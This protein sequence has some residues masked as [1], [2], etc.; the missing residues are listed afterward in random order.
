MSKTFIL[1]KIGIDLSRPELLEAFISRFGNPTMIIS[2]LIIGLACI[3]IFLL[4]Q[5]SCSYLARL[6]LTYISQ[7]KKFS[8]SSLLREWRG[9]WSWAGT[10]LVV[11]IYFIGASMITALI[12]IGCIY[13]YDILAIIP[14]TLGGITLL[15]L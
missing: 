7:K 13:V 9:M 11:A 4:F 10:G 15:F 2:I 12:A 1:P 14:I 6:G 3:F 8:F 5:L